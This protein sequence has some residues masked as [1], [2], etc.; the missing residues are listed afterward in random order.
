MADSMYL[1]IEAQSLVLAK[2]LLHDSVVAM[3]LPIENY[4]YLVGERKLGFAN[5]KLIKCNPVLEES[6][7]GVYVFEFDREI[8]AQV[9][10]LVDAESKKNPKT[11]WCTSSEVQQYIPQAVI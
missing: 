9:G 5:G 6:N 10:S 1:V 4:Q 11:H 2:K 3:K 7:T 8:V